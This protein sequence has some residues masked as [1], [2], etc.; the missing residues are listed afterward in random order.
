MELIEQIQQIQQAD[1]VADVE[2]RERQ[3]LV[4]GDFEGSVT[5]YWVKL[6][7]DGAGVVSYNNKK[8]VTKPIGFTSLPAGQAVELSHANG[9]YYSSW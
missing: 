1:R 3:E 5:G 4:Q 7:E 6:R 9:V 8:Y 2:R